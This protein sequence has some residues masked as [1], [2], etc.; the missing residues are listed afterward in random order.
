[1]REPAPV[2]PDDLPEANII[3]LIDS[4]QRFAQALAWFSRGHRYELNREYADALAAFE[5]ALELDPDHQETYYR[6]ALNLMRVQRVAEAVDLLQSLVE[7]SPESAQPHIWLGSAHRQQ[8]NHEA[9][10][11]AYSAALER[12]ATNEALY[13][14]VVDLLIQRDKETEAIALL[15]V[16]VERANEPLNLYRILGEL[17]MRRAVLSTDAQVSREQ[18]HQAI[19]ALTEAALRAPNEVSILNTLADLYLRQREVDTAIT[20]LERI[21]VLE[22]TDLSVKERLALAYELTGRDR[23][24]AEQLELLAAAQPTNKRVFLA[25]AAMYER[26]GETEKAILNYQLASRL[27]DPDPAPFLKLAVLQMEDDPDQA[28]K[29]VLDGLAQMPDNP[30]LLEMLGYVRFNREEYA[31]ALESFAQ[32]EAAW[33]S[34]DRTAMSPNF[35]LYFALAH[36]FEGL[37]DDLKAPLMRALEVTPEAAETFTHFIFQDEDETRVANLIPVYKAILEEWSDDLNLRLMLAYLLSFNKDYDK[38]LA[39]FAETK[40]RALQQERQDLLTARFYFW[41]AAANERAGNLEEAERLF[42]QCLELDPEHVEAYN[43]LAY[44][45]AENSVNLDQAKTYVLIALEARPD[46][47]AFID[48]LGWIY[49]QQGRYEEAYTEI[50]RAL[51]ILPDDPTILDHMGDIYYKL[52]Q[53]EQA[54]A[55][56]KRAFELDRENEEL[57]AKLETHDL[58]LPEHAEPDTADQEK[59]PETDSAPS[60]SL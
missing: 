29:D 45:W 31:K 3:D 59:M 21:A 34:V 36:Y 30:Q 48:T 41:F 17:H 13:V 20:Y 8:N 51:E 52:D 22:P 32:A 57:R 19:S 46:S 1:M 40:E 35:H 14:Q 16:G 37:M 12:D 47:A 5:R 27:G 4:D 15:E 39:Q 25:L 7:R 42:Y 53:P 28:L 55:K 49:Y 18:L 33:S 60:T 38:A 23:D 43:Y 2:V 54:H 26:L 6:I 11:A 56:W 9:A 10:L 44:M 24:A 58:A 50:K